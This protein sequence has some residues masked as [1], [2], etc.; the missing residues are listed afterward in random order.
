MVT[1]VR[2]EL[3][4][5]GIEQLLRSQEV[6]QDLQRRADAVAAAAGEGVRA[7]VYQ[8]RDRVRAQVW[9]AT[10]AAKKA[11]AEDRTLLKALDAARD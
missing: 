5:Q 2:I 4:S 7:R 8:G 10:A 1:A 9:T 11:E 3:D 6:G